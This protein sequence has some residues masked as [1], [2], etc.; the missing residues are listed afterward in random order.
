ME[1]HIT[2][3]GFVV[4]EGKTAL[5]WHPKLGV[6]LPAG[7]HIEPNEDPAQAVL[8]EIEEE[9]GV[10]AS[11][12]PLSPRVP[13]N[14]GPAHIEA[15]HAMLDCYPAPDHGH[16][17]CVYYCRVE[18]GYPGVS[19]DPDSPIIWLDAAALEQGA[20]PHDGA[21][22]PIPPDVQAL[23]LEAIRQA[24]RFG[25]ESEALEF[26]AQTNRAEVLPQS[27]PNDSAYS[28]PATA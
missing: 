3:S 14:G 6:W 1:R 23:G 11:I 17:D 26:I 18:S 27:E 15:P 19:Y 10:K 22:V 8:R 21:D 7:G 12:L 2:V 13:Y 24:A 25:A 28:T 20:L 5:H 16:I 4:H 9:F